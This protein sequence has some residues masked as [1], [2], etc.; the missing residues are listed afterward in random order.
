[1]GRK[2]LTEEEEFFAQ[3]RA[4]EQ[5]L[6]YNK[7]YY[8]KN[9]ALIMAKRRQFRLS[10]P[11]GVKRA[12]EKQKIKRSLSKLNEF[13]QKRANFEDLKWTNILVFPQCEQDIRRGL[14]V[15][16][17]AVTLQEFGKLFLVIGTTIAHW[18]TK[19]K[20][21]DNLVI[22]KCKLLM[23]YIGRHFYISE[24][25]VKEVI[26]IRDVYKTVNGKAVFFERLD[27]ILE[28]YPDGIKIQYTLNV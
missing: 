28:K 12:N 10:N 23:P 27:K 25:I 26:E 11:N 7:E 8:E 5:R 16:I 14:P 22:T 13:M 18:K 15:L 21:F 20:N 2:R 9:K 4:Q 1:M 17:K 3:Q 6:S 19:L 24:D